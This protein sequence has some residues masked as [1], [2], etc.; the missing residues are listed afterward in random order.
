MSIAKP[1]LALPTPSL[2]LLKGVPIAEVT[3]SVEL[4]VSMLCEGAQYRVAESRIP[5]G[6]ILKTAMYRADGQHTFT[7]IL[8]H[9]S[10][11]LWT[12]G[13]KIPDLGEVLLTHLPEADEEF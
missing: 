2:P 1:P 9:P 5:P 12:P 3:V 10:F 8:E 6:A 13:T 11:P 4:L 7:F